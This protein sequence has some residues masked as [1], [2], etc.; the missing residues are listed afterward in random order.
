MEPFTRE[1][2]DKVTV[3]FCVYK[4]LNEWVTHLGAF[5]ALGRDMVTRDISFNVTDEDFVEVASSKHY[6]ICHTRPMK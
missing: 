1:A 4:L 3:A 2:H 5:L 6:D